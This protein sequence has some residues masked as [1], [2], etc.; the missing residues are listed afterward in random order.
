MPRNLQFVWPK[1]GPKGKGGH[2]GF[3][4]RLDN[5]LTGKG[6]D[7]FI[8]AKGSRESIPLDWWS[9]WDSYHDFEYQARENGED[10]FGKASRGMMRYDPHTRKYVKW[11]SPGDWYG[12]RITA[13]PNGGP[14]GIAHY[15]RFTLDEWKQIRKKYR[16]GKLI[17]PK[18]MGSEWNSMGPKRF[19]PK[20]D[21]YWQDAHRVGENYRE[22]FIREFSARP[23][24]QMHQNSIW[25]LNDYIHYDVEDPALTEFPFWVP[26]N[27]RWS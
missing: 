12:E 15:P 9:N 1:E 25:D 18:A 4:G 26:R 7:V 8:Q 27:E 14:I 2:R 10:S 13:D 20:H 5:I 21:M 24:M 22:G 11:G 16:K 3:W 17:D 19:E 6:P 23:N